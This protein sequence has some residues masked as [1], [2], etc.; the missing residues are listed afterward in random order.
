MKEV[1]KDYNT[2]DL[3]SKRSFKVSKT[4]LVKKLYEG[5]D[6][7]K[8][9]E[10]ALNNGY[11]AIWMTKKDG[12]RTARYVHKM[13]AET[14]LANPKNKRYVLHLDHD[15]LNNKSDNL[16]WANDAEWKEHNK[17]LFRMMKGRSRLDNIPNSK[18]TEKQVRS[19]KKKLANPNK[20][21]KVAALAKQ[22]NISQGQIYRIIRGDNWA[23]IK[24]D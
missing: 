14:F 18:L 23:H 12:K 5:T 7:Y 20:K 4:G 21:V 9:L 15:K 19:L 13:V 24:V 2:D 8:I 16:K 1:W 6:K 11:K 3:A 17:E 22:Y 10:G